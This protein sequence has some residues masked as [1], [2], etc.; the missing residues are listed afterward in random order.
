MRTA[1]SKANIEA[2]KKVLTKED[3]ILDLRPLTVYIMKESGC[4]FAE[5]GQ[6]FDVT[7]QNAKR[8]YEVAKGL[9]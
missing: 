1:Q 8:L 7:R 9:V 6:V 3:G 5:I 4:T 2:L